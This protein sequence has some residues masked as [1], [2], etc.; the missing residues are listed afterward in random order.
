MDIRLKIK[1]IQRQ[2]FRLNQVKSFMQS[3]MV[4]LRLQQ[5]DLKGNETKTTNLIISD[6]DA[7]F[8]IMVFQLFELRQVIKLKQEPSLEPFLVGSP[9]RLPMPKNYGE[10]DAK[11]FSVVARHKK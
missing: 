4:R 5:K 2:R 11:R 3:W 10:V 1:L 9:K 8:I 7:R 6:S